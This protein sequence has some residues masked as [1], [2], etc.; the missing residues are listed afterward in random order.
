[1]DGCSRWCIQGR[2][3]GLGVQRPS[4]F[5]PSPLV[6]DAPTAQNQEEM[7]AMQ[8]NIELLS[9]RCETAEAHIARMDKYMK[10]HMPHFYDDEETDSDV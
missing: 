8:K 6:S 1:M 5:R 7:G 10:K 9:R 3:Y 2:V 4:S